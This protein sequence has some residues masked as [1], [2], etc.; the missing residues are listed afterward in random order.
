MM[1]GG[2]RILCETAVA[3]DPEIFSSLLKS[4]LALY[5]DEKLVKVEETDLGDDIENREFD[6]AYSKLSYGSV[7]E[8][9]PTAEISS[10]SQYFITT[11]CSLSRTQ[12]GYAQLIRSAVDANEG[13]VL[14]SLMSKFGQKME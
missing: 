9:D 8:I 13:V 1:I 2:T 3:Q 10:G 4:I 7:T 14:Q 12:A 6:S 11:L 5:S